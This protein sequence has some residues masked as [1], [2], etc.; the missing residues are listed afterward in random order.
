MRNGKGVSAAEF[1]DV[2]SYGASLMPPELMARGKSN[3][4]SDDDFNFQLSSLRAQVL[5]WNMGPERL[6]GRKRQTG[7]TQ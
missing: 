1:G 4:P 6:D 3:I 5:T 2:E 7:N